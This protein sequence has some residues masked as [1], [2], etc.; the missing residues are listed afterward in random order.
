MP[1]LEQAFS[2]KQSV[3]AVHSASLPPP[4]CAG[5][6][7]AGP[8]ADQWPDGCLGYA[9]N[10]VR[11]VRPGQRAAVLYPLLSGTLVFESLDTAHSYK[12]FMATVRCYPRRMSVFRIG[13]WLPCCV[14][15]AYCIAWWP[16]ISCCGL[17]TENRRNRI[18]TVDCRA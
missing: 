18:L 13:R 7:I 2:Q 10:L 3:R 4:R 12:E 9:Y 17:R 8:K 14:C 16:S 11:P 15:G 6:G 1:K 5:D